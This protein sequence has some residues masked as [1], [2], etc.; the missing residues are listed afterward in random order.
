MLKDCFIFTPMIIQLDCRY[1]KTLTK[2]EQ[3]ALD[4][5]LEFRSVVVQDFNKN[6]ETEKFL[7]ENN[8]PKYEYGPF[9]FSLKDISKFNLV[10]ENHIC[11]RFYGGEVYVFRIS[12][13]QFKII[14]QN[15]T[16]NIIINSEVVME[17]A[18]TDSK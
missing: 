17:D 16:G 12:F 14:Y 15:L 3:S 8:Y 10:D 18:K 7:E 13:E 4:K 2:K 5:E 11:I 6:E 1:P 9:V